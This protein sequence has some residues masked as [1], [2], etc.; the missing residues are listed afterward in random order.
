[1]SL[2]NRVT[3]VLTIIIVRKQVK[4]KLIFLPQPINWVIQ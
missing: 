2:M 1:M 4:F 3:N